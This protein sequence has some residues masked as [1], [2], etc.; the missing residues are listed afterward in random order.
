MA[1]NIVIYKNLEDKI[2]YGSVPWTPEIIQ[3]TAWYDASD[4]GTIT[5]DTGFV[6]QLDDKSGNGNHLTQETADDQP[7]TGSDTINGLNV[8]TFSDTSD[9]MDVGSNIYANDPVTECFAIMVTTL[10]TTGANGFDITHIEGTTEYLGSRI[11]FFTTVINDY[12][13]L[14]FRQQYTHGI[15]PPGDI[16]QAIQ[17]DGGAETGTVWRDGALTGSSRSA[18]ASIDSGN[19]YIEN[20]GNLAEWIIIES[21][22]STADRQKL[23]GYLAWKWGFQSILPS[24]HPYENGAPTL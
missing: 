16:M 21:V 23:E 22:V 9:R 4:T 19:T 2:R 18:Q 13:S 17:Y 3:T 24:G 10:T 12:G 20:I 6:S 15:T 1:T 7:A 8:L 14:S 5:E 11:P